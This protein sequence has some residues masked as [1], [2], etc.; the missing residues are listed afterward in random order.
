MAFDMAF[1]SIGS[2]RGFLVGA[3]DTL[4]HVP[5]TAVLHRVMECFRVD[6]SSIAPNKLRIA[7]KKGGMWRN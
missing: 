2:D 5:A 7:P 6:F 4:I 1:F 3:N